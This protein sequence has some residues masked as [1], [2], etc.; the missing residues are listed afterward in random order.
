MIMEEFNRHTIEKYLFRVINPK[1]NLSSAWKTTLQCNGFKNK[2][3]LL[4][5]PIWEA[6]H[7]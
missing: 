6:T 3:M 4:F 7:L 1:I 2:A 5:V